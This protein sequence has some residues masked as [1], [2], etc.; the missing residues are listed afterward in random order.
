MQDVKVGIYDSENTSSPAFLPSESLSHNGEKDGCAD[1]NPYFSKFVWMVFITACVVILFSWII[2]KT[3]QERIRMLEAK[4]V[5]EKQAT[6]LEA[7]NLRLENEYLALK[8]D[9]VRIEKEARELLGFTGTDEIIYKKYN[10]R[11]K[12]TAPIE[13]EKIVSRNRWK[14]F[15]FDGV[16]PWQFPAVVILI[17]VAYYSISYHYEYR[18]LHKSNC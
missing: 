7:E 9:P 16:F 13:P 11:I 5:L 17:A 12:S 18:K 3:R 8:K 10:F 15:L 2:S 4:K 14:A 1:R 6:R